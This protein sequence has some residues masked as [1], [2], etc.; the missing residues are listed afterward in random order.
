MEGGSAEASQ[1][2]TNER[3]YLRGASSPARYF[4]SLLDI[5]FRSLWDIALSSSFD[6]SLL[7]P[8]NRNDGEDDRA[9]RRRCPSVLDTHWNNLLDAKMLESLHCGAS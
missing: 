7:R 9:V 8:D 6:R 3:P 1:T 2:H 5:V 4:P